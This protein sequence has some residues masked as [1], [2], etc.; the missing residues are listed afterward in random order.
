MGRLK[1]TFLMICFINTWFFQNLA[2]AEISAFNL[3]AEDTE[4]AIR[5]K[6]DLFKQM[7]IL[8]TDCPSFY[9]FSLDYKSKFVNQYYC[10]SIH[11]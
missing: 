4:L 5:N 1:T 8:P 3:P 6:L 11:Y 10:I 9:K 7:E 2:N